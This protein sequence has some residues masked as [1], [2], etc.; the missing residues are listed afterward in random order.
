M[1]T[2]SSSIFAQGYWNNSSDEWHC[3]LKCFQKHLMR[4]ILLQKLWLFSS[5]CSFSSGKP[6]LWKWCR[7][8]LQVG[9]LLIHESLFYC[10][11]GSFKLDLYSSG[12][13]IEIE[14]EFL[15]G[16]YPLIKQFHFQSRILEFCIVGILHNQMQ[17]QYFLCT[18]SAQ[19]VNTVFLHVLLSGMVC[20]FSK[21][22]E[23]WKYPSVVHHYLYCK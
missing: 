15:G 17:L 18:K 12:F 8:W 14:I 22:I 21:N 13:W 16:L 6:F 9:M 5:A 3:L 7:G 11:S 20:S 2:L 1:W 4:S 23:F 10:N 19:Y